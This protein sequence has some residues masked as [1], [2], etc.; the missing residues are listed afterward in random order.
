MIRQFDLLNGDIYRGIPKSF[1][2]D[3]YKWEKTDKVARLKKEA[4]LR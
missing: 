2:L 3:G 4:G 1:F